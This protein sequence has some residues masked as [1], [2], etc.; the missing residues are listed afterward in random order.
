MIT[1]SKEQFMFYEDLV[2]AHQESHHLT[3]SL[4]G[5]VWQARFAVQLC[6]LAK[7]AFQIS[8]C[9]EIHLMLECVT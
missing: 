4:V 5:N 3:S 9:A 1:S 8:Y 7:S 2:A 6:F